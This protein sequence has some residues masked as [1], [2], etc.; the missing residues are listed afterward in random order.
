[1]AK[2]V[3]T[4]ILAIL[5]IIQIFYLVSIS[6]DTKS[7]PK[8]KKQKQVTTIKESNTG[9]KHF[10]NFMEKGSLDQRIRNHLS[11]WYKKPIEEVISE[12]EKQ[13]V[14]NPKN[15]KAHFE[16]A[17]IYN[18][19]PSKHSKALK[20]FQITN[21]L[22]PHYPEKKTI[23][24]HIYQLTKDPLK[25]KKLR[26]KIVKKYK[27]NTK[28][29]AGKYY[30]KAIESKEKGKLRLAK[31]YQRMALQRDNTNP[32]YHYYYAKLHF[33]DNIMLAKRHLE[34]VLKLSPNHREKKF[35]KKNIEYFKK[36]G[37]K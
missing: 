2:K 1:M 4:S 26:Q 22:N 30:Q 21:K 12:Y 35:I 32:D 29:F 7:E 14:K 20:H 33:K 34:T 18:F 5:I 3:I 28:K 37:R 6:Q 15:V 10:Q 36:K 17:K 11:K 19:F 16:L 8:Y 24:L 9:K 23:D 25:R 27:V 31:M 13:I